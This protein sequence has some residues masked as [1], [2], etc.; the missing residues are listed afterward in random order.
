MWLEPKEKPFQINGF[1]WF[2]REKIFRRLPEKPEYK[3]P[4]SVDILANHTAGGLIRFRTDSKFLIL[5]VKLRELSRMPH[6]PATGQSGFDC[7]IGKSTKE[8]YCSTAIPD[9]NSLE[10]ERKLFQFE[11]KEIRDVSLYFPLYMGVGGVWVGIENGSNVLEP[12]PFKKKG[13]IVVYGTSITQGG[14]ASRP[15]MAY[16][17]I[18]SRWLGI[19]FINLGFSGSGKGEKELAL[20]I[21]EI[22]NVRCIVLDYQANAGIEGYI[23]TLPDF[24]K[25]LRSRFKKTPIIILSRPAVSSWFF[26]KGLKKNWM[27]GFKFQEDFVRK[28]NKQDNNIFSYDGSKLFSEMWQES[29]VDGAHPTDLGFLTMAKA[30]YPVLKAIIS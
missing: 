13:R 25:I 3:I 23:A 11:K 7:Y 22:D 12:L 26:D 20:L 15:G 21:T 2:D 1:A 16:T 4:E 5:K 8:T 6:M 24:V 17:N 9:V 29:T 30:L 18:L 28:L 27:K 14:C 10:Y 19:E